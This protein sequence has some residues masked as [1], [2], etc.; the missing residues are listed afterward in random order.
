MILRVREKPRLYKRKIYHVS[1][2]RSHTTTNP[3]ASDCGPGLYFVTM[4][5]FSTFSSGIDSTEVLF[6]GTVISMHENDSPQHLESFDE[7]AEECDILKS[8]RQHLLNTFRQLS[9]SNESRTAQNPIMTLPIR[10]GLQKPTSDSIISS[11]NPGLLFCYLFDDWYAG[12][13][14][15][16]QE[17]HHQFG[18][19]L[20]EIVSL[21]LALLAYD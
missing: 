18:T 2:K 6:Q 7:G 15:V 9:K 8:T 14:L 5:I 10:L 13:S 21:S 1:T 12:Y 16:A 4:V 20:Q 17:G 11:D 19:K 3:T